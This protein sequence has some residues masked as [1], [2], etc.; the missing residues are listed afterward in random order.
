MR[1]ADFD[2]DLPGEL[3]AQRPPPARDDSRM[4]IVERQTGKISHA[5]FREFPGF[6]S[7]DDVL[8]LN[9]TRVIPAKAWGR[10]SDGSRIE[11]LFVR[12]TAPGEWECLAKPARKAVPGEI[13]S[14]P[15]GFIARVVEAGPEG[16]RVLAFDRSDLRAGLATFGYAPLPPYI[17]RPPEAVAYRDEDLD[18]YQTVFACRE[19]SIAA[20]TAGLHFTPRILAGLENK[21][22]QVHRI[23][24]NVGRATFQP[25]RVDEVEGH[26]MLEETC[27]VS[28]P[29]AE[30]VNTARRAGRPVA[31][32]GTTV[33]RTLESSWMDGLVRSGR[34]RTSMFIY[35]G[36]E[37][38]IVDRLLTNF[39]LP[40]STLLMLVSAFAGRELILEA[41]HEAV[42]KKY[43]FYSYGDCMMIL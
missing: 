11:I 17:K 15:G 33:V 2:F 28:A 29:T 6:L 24:L 19:G 27:A 16:T 41:Y 34:R 26:I 37:F 42:A 1:V 9:D 38:K 36:Y 35:P 12:D 10:R 13:I 5:S 31:A 8:V 32:V 7:T 22:V 39:H 23:T 20:P 3:I 21:G 30:A 4:M 18:R 40:Q 14:F 25:V 43:R